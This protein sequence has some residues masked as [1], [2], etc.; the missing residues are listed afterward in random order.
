MI[1]LQIVFWLAALAVAIPLVLYPV[2]LFA[3]SRLRSRCAAGHATPTA[4]LVISAFNEEDV[5]RQKLENSLALDYP[6]ELLEIL[7]ISDGSEDRTDEIVAGFTDPRVQ[8]R[9][10][11]PRLGKSAGLSRYCPEANG[12]IL[13]FTDANSMFQPDALSKLLRHF[14]DPRV[15]YSVGRQSYTDGDQS[16]SSDSENLYWSMELLMK[17]WESRLSSVV[18]ADGAIYALRR[19]LFE[20]LSAE[21]INDF[22]LPLK[23]VAKGYRGVFDHEAVCFED[24][25]PDF[26]G[27]FRRKRRIV[28]RSMRAVW[29]VPSTLNPF[30]VGWF[31]P[32]LLA[33]K[34]LRWLCPLFLLL[35]LVSAAVLAGNEWASGDLGWIYTGLLFLQLLGYG[36]AL[37]YVIPF[38][39]RVRLVYVA[40]YFLL[41]N[42]ASAMGLA[43]LASGH[44]IGVWKPE[45]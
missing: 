22:L 18:G 4:T 10:Q 17:A 31:A 45:R 2:G 6:S 23:V 37:A 32:Q 3:M 29:K 39:R 19:E 1:A 20:P 9:R 15:G 11:D 36:L 14:D 34:V 42:V 8:L 43:L 5:I 33:H 24:A 25:A 26:S 16:S 44:A 21:D 41:V 12:E 35:M 38:F 27:E 28:N 13:V 30:R 7:V 40:Y